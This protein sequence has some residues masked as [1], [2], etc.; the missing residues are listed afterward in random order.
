M[1]FIFLQSH[2]FSQEQYFFSADEIKNLLVENCNEEF[3]IR[4][5]CS[6]LKR[7]LSVKEEQALFDLNY[8]LKDDLLV[9]VDRASM[10]FSLEART[11]FLDYRVV[12]FA[13]NLNEN[14]KLK[15]GTS[16]YL[17]KE[18]LFDYVP[19]EYFN[20]PKWGFSIPLKHWLKKELRH[21]V[22]FYLSKEMIEKHG[23]INFIEVK[24]IISRFMNGEE[25]LY[26]RIWNLMILHQWLE[27]ENR[28]DK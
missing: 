28:N 7:N 21:L 2:I 24:N 14:L 17:L 11:P 25:Y 8:Y 10:K 15:N 20:R 16:K 1:R 6:S 9:K 18:L 19:R 26:N 22:D 27:K 4:Q 23:V 3:R 5:N 12:E 13:L